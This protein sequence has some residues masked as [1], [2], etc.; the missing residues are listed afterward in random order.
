MNS[1]AIVREQQQPGGLPLIGD[2]FVAW[3][4]E[5]TNILQAIDSTSS[6]A[7]S[8]PHGDPRPSRPGFTHGKDSCFLVT[9]P[10]GKDLSGQRVHEWSGLPSS[11]LSCTAS[12]RSDRGECGNP[13][14]NRAE[15]LPL[16]QSFTKPSHFLH[17]CLPE[18]FL[19]E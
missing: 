1:I 9:L 7:Q 16:M 14:L 11:C 4:A 6:T 3:R 12:R 13:R 19:N 10:W 18:S 2:L 8:K 17:E 5:N 15:P